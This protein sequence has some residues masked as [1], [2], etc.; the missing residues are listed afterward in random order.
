MTDESKVCAKNHQNGNELTHIPCTVLKGVGQKV[1][2]YLLKLNIV[3]VQDLLFHLPLR[4]EDRTSIKPMSRLRL[5]D[6][7]LVEGE[8]VGSHVQ[9]S[10]R[11]SLACRIQDGAGFLTIR[12]FHFNAGHLKCFSQMGQRLRCYGEIRRGP[13]GYE[14]VHPE[15]HFIEMDVENT[16]SLS[17][18]LTP[19]YP[20]TAGVQQH[21]LRKITEQAIELLEE[22]GRLRE[23]LPDSILTQF[24]LIDLASAIKIVHRPP[25]RGCQR[26]LRTRLNH[27]RQRLSFEELLAHYLSLAK[28]RHKTMLHKAPNI[29]LMNKLL[30]TFVNSLPYEL[31]R[32]QQK[33]LK[34][35]LK[36]MQRGYPMARLLQGDVGSGKTVVAAMAA[37][38]VIE[39]GYQVALMVP[40]EL[41]AEQHY[42]SFHHWFSPLNMAVHLLTGS[43]RSGSREQTLAQISAG[44][45][46]MVIGTHA[47]F[48]DSVV[49]KR[50][51]LIIIDEQHRFGVTQRLALLNKGVWSDSF[52]HQLIMSATPIPR[53][54]AMIG[55]ADLDHSQIDE[56]PPNRKPIKTSILPNTRRDQ[57]VARVKESC[58]KGTQAYWVCTLI[59]ES[60]VLQC[61]AAEEV[62]KELTLK[63]PGLKIAIIHGRMKPKEKDSIMAAFKDKRIDLLVATTVIEVGVDVPNA[64]LMVIENSERLGLFQL[65]QLRGRVGRGVA[66]SHCVLLYQPPLTHLPK[67]RLAAIKSIHD[68]FL[69]AQKD[70]ELRGPGEVL[71]VRQTGELQL[72]V[73]DLERDQALLPSVKSAA[74]TL[75]QHYP[76]HIELLVKRW[77]G[78]NLK[79]SD[80]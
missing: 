59:E 40:T 27:A 37:L 5:G 61:Q 67:Q 31:T 39:S 50:L 79:F 26:L 25:S 64:S 80:V 14:M 2:A 72:K 70:L 55:Y 57:L 24:N 36:D 52:P 20:S 7:A 4:Y 10:S 13:T 15:Y 41:L 29:Q 76:E 11:K 46:H 44:N 34:E 9:S 49:F 68:G 65:H 77:L 18:T 16:Q 3:S 60:E 19:I 12:F 58:L 8:I 73:A 28:I 1:A 17:S 54:L 75:L 66:S 45:A 30:P 63:L 6:H 21:L 42:L 78:G 38:C 32:A 51:G 22:R 69:L 74:E 53:T 43:N 23:C 33:T 35:I 48:Q 62:W 56:L 71:G 47:L